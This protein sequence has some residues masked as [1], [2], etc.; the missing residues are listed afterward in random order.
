[1]TT[2]IKQY[3][4]TADGVEYLVLEGESV[5][6]C[7]AR[8]DSYHYLFDK[9]NGN[10]VRWG[11]DKNDDPLYCPAGPEMLDL[12]ISVNGCPNNCPFCYKGNNDQPPYNMTFETFKTVFDKIPKILTQ[13]AFGITGVQTNPDFL[14]MMWYC[15]ENGVIPNFTLTGADLT[16]ELAVEI[17]RVVGALAVSVHEHDKNIGY[18]TVKKFTDLGIDQTN[19]HLMVSEET[20]EFAMSMIMDRI[21]DPRLSDMNAVVFLGLKPKGRA[22]G[23]Y[24]PLSTE[25]YKELIKFCMDSNIRY[26]FDSC[27]APKFEKTVDNLEI[28]TGEKT[29]LKEL[30]ESCESSLFSSYINAKSEYWPCSFCEGERNQEGIDVLGA[31]DFIKDVWHHSV[32]RDFRKQLL[33]SA[34]NGCRECIVFPEINQ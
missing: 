9:G 18:D 25:K 4:Y 3:S 27:S 20:L 14:K 32:T 30:S 5:K 19:I 17:S 11:V 34:K 15:R 21:R 7:Y 10:F 24:T 31:K 28:S 22:V 33:H 16:D 1:M 29:R 12:E 26:G 2:D 13:V 6:V 8:D 23:H